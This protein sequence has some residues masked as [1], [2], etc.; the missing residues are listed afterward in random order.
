MN[1]HLLSPLALVL[2]L[3]LASSAGAHVVLEYQVAPADSAYK[4]TFKVGHGCGSAATRQVSVAIPAGVAGARPMPKPGWT[5]EI[6][7]E[8]LAQ[9]FTSHGRTVT[10]DVTRITWTARSAADA[11]P[12]DQYDEFVLVAQLPGRAGPLYWPLSQVCDP[13]RLDWVEVPKPGQSIADLKS[14]AAVLEVLPAAGASS[15]RH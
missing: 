12:S 5:V 15:H 14:P 9:P 11:L 2:G 4:A 3:G 7:R 6:Q 13:G 10:E 1:H 8:K